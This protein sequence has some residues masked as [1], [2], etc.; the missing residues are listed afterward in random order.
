MLCTLVYL[1]AIGGTEIRCR[2]TSLVLISCMNLCEVK[3]YYELLLRTVIEL[4]YRHGNI[5][6]IVIDTLALL[7]HNILNKTDQIIRIPT[8]DIY[9]LLRTIF[10]LGL[11]NS[12]PVTLQ[13]CCYTI[14]VPILK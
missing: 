14:E 8:Q 13:H 1:T 2:F 6:V 11:Y 10:Y 3:L 4:K 7:V 5:G 9:R 12:N